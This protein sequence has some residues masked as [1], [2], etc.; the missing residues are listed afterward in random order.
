LIPSLV[1]YCIGVGLCIG[2]VLVPVLVVLR[3]RRRTRPGLPIDPQVVDA[4]RRRRLSWPCAP[5][6]P[7]VRALHAPMPWER[8]YW[9]RAPKDGGRRG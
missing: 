5:V 7:A 3:R 6:L 9:R 2:L 4:L 1:R 8:A